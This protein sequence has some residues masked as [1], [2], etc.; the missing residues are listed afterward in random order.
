MLCSASSVSVVLVPAVYMSR[1]KPISSLPVFNVRKPKCYY[2]QCLSLAVLDREQIQE[3]WNKAGLRR[4]V[5]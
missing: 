1:L 5:R 3:G 2:F 4:V